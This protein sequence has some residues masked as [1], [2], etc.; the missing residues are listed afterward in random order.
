MKINLI[1]PNKQNLN[2]FVTIGS[3]IILVGFFDFLANTFLGVN[4]TGF[5][6]AGLSY[7]MP[8]IFGVVGLHLIRIEFSGNRLLD[9]IN[10]NFNSSNFNA[11]LSL[12]VIFVLIK[13]ITVSYTHLTLTTILLV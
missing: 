1:K 8:I 11:F 7:F 12:L 2:T 10:T 4:F 5:L 6:P 3:I 9:K 13:Y